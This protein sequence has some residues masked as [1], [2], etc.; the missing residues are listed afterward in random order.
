[1]ITKQFYVLLILIA[2][3]VAVL[4]DQLVHKK[5]AG[6]ALGWPYYVYL[7]FAT[8]ISSLIIYALK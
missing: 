3:V 6:C 1:M 7:I 8:I 5:L 2:D 4:L